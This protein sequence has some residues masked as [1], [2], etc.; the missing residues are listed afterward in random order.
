MRIEFLGTGGATTTPRVGRQ[1]AICES[2]LAGGGFTI[3]FAH[4]RMMVE[5]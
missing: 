4:D 5:V 1:C 3:T 2:E